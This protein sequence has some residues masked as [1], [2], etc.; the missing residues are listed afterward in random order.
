MWNTYVFVC[1]RQP[2][3]LICWP[4][5]CQHLFARRKNDCEIHSMCSWKQLPHNN[6]VFCLNRISWNSSRHLTSWGHLGP[7]KVRFLGQ[8]LQL[9]HVLQLSFGPS[10]IVNNILSNFPPWNEDVFLVPVRAGRNAW[11]IND[12]HNINRLIDEFGKPL[13]FMPMLHHLGFFLQMLSTP[14]FTSCISLEQQ[15]KHMSPCFSI[16]SQIVTAR[17]CLAT[18]KIQC[19]SALTLARLNVL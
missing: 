9:A 19:S 18:A 15:E 5:K 2:P 3:W 13:T 1:F 4:Y 14:Y 12:K 10:Y 6:L 11:W 17:T 16:D 8:N 7:R